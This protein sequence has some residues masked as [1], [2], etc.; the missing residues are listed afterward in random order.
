[1]NAS[2]VAAKES[3]GGGSCVTNG[4]HIWGYAP[5]WCSESGISLDVVSW[6]MTVRHP[7]HTVSA[8]DINKCQKG[9]LCCY[10]LN[11]KGFL[12]FVTSL[13]YQAILYSF[14]HRSY[15]NSCFL[16]HRMA[17]SLSL[18]CELDGHGGEFTGKFSLRLGEFPLQQ[19]AE[20]QGVDLRVRA[21]GERYK[22]W[23]VR[24]LKV[25]VQ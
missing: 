18:Q 10:R 6:V 19:R 12:Q 23:F 8:F 5:L 13:Y 11:N 21:C 22:L 3:K 14:L 9:E 16:K 7:P 15:T 2:S 24:V 1:M 4:N 20:L 17:L 25:F